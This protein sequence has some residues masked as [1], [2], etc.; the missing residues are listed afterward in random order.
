M[1]RIGD[2][3]SRKEKKAS[4]AQESDEPHEEEN[5]TAKVDEPT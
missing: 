5:N 4:N 3:L 1:A 2:W